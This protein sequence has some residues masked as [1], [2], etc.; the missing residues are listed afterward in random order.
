MHP[1]YLIL[2]LY[3]LLP[4]LIFTHVV[5]EDS[6]AGGIAQRN[7]EKIVGNFYKMLIKV[8]RKMR[9]K[10]INAE[11]LKFFIN[12]IFHGEYIPNSSDINEIFE[13][14]NRHR[15][16]DYWN[17]YPLENIVLVFAIDDPKLTF[18]M[19]TYRQD[20]ESYKVTTKIIHH[21]AAVNAMPSE[22]EDHEQPARY[23]R[24]YYQTLSL[25]LNTRVTVRSLK[26]IDDLWNKFANLYNLPPR[27]ALLDHIH[28]GCVSVVWYIPSYLAPQIHLAPLSNAFY[29]KHEIT[30]V[31]F[32]GRCIYQEDEGHHVSSQLQ[33]HDE[34]YV[35]KERNK[36]E[37]QGNYPSCTCD[38]VNVVHNPLMRKRVARLLSAFLVVSSQLQLIWTRLVL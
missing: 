33:H 38:N 29:R 35:N 10:P 30:R 7:M 3:I 12:G 5:Q 15:L 6:G 23:D 21:I 27:V 9:E 22:E 34:V 14:V 17:Y 16:W 11:D 26:Y 18:L 36:A 8:R 19:E 24:R 20:L 2:W 4:I 1:Q 25:K 28:R 32:D 31:E 37:S 13:A